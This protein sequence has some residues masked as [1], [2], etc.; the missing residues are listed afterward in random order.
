M[1]PDKPDKP[2][3][4]IRIVFI[5][6][7]ENVPVDANMHSPLHVARDRA[8]T[9]SHNTGRPLHEWEI[10]DEK[11]TLLPP[12]AKIESFNFPNNVRLFLSLKVGAG[13]V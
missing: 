7:G 6:N 4:K 9:Q 10:R 13:G 3:N 5:I 2:E 12:D 8:L 11:G 1:P